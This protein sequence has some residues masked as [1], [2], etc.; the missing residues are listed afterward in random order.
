MMLARWE[1]ATASSDLWEAQF[2]SYNLLTLGPSPSVKFRG[3]NEEKPVQG[4]IDAVPKAC[5]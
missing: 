4:P 3:F 5:F 1:A 2:M